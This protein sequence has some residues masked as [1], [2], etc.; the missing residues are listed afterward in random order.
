[1]HCL[2]PNYISAH[3]DYKRIFSL[4]LNFSLQDSNLSKFDC[5]NEFNFSAAAR[6]FYSFSDTRCSSP[7]LTGVQP[8]CTKNY[9]DI[10]ECTIRDS[11][12]MTSLKELHHC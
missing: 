3:P 5:K 2:P 10:P 1:M 9:Q 6:C 7:F 11:S 4:S 8:S 12:L